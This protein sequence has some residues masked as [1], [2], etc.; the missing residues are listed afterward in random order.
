[1]D[2]ALQHAH[3]PHAEVS[4]DAIA[5]AHKRCRFVSTLAFWARG[6]RDLL[7]A[8]PPSQTPPPMPVPD[9]DMVIRALTDDGSFRVL[10]ARTT[11]VCATAVAHQN[12]SGDTAR[13]FSDLLTG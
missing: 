3:A 5:L 10:T 1:T 2:P 9:T 8:L 6:T 7:G 11:S 4:R 12:V 13:H